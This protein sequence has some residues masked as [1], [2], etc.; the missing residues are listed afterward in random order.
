MAA[1]DRYPTLQALYEELTR[2]SAV[3]V[4]RGAREARGEVSLNE[5]RDV[6]RVSVPWVGDF[7]LTGPQREVV[8]L[9]VDAYLHSRSPEM[10]ESTLLQMAGCRA[11]KLAVVFRGSPAWGTLIVRGS[12]PYLY[13]LPPMPGDEPEPEPAPPDPQEPRVVP[14]ED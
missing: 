4:A 10:A 6:T 1:L 3:E 11:S 14:P 12:K 7:L 13:R 2:L 8:R 5:G 9:L